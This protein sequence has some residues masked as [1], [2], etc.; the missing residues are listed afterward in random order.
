MIPRQMAAFD[1]KYTTEQREAMV[2]YYDERGYSAP[3]IVRLAKA[4]ELRWKGKGLA[5]FGPKESTI[6]AEVS[7]VR[8]RREG[9]EKRDLASLPPRDAI[10]ALRRRLLNV[11]DAEMEYE[12]KKKPG[13]RDLKRMTEISRLAFEA[14]RVPGPK[15]PRPAQGQAPG[16]DGRK[17]P[18]TRTGLAGDLLK[19]HRASVGRPLNTDQVPGTNGQ[20]PETAGTGETPDDAG[21]SDAAGLLA[22]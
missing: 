9:K 7:K 19:D 12:E 2:Y 1:T 13:S 18:V 8:R 3:Q 10:E 15:E 21:V 11:A 22:R 14:S 17:G 16:I 6:R 20:A 4:G 5:S